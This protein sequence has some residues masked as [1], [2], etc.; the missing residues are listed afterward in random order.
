MR[1]HFQRA[2][3]L[4]GLLAALPAAQAGSLNVANTDLTLSGG[5][6]AGVFHTTNNG[7]T[8][9]TEYE[10]PDFLLELSSAADSEVGFTAAFGHLAGA[11]LWDG[12]VPAVD[13]GSMDVQYGYLTVPVGS[14]VTVDAGKLATMIGYEVAPS[15][16]NS[17]ILLGSV[18]YEQPV[19]YKGVRAT[20]SA[21]GFSAY[22]EANDDPVLGG[23]GPNADGKSVVFGASTSYGGYDWL[24]SYG[25][26]F[27]A[28]NILDLIVSGKVGGIDGAINFDYQSL[29][30]NAP[31]QDD[32]AYGIALYATFPASAMVTVPVR[33]EY[34]S[35]GTSGLYE[36]VDSAYTLTI[37]PTYHASES[38]F[39]RGELAYISADNKIFADDKGQPKD[40]NTS[41]VLEAGVTL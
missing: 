31:G 22:A 23:V 15:Y 25:N 14:A 18:W 10:V 7:S 24:A 16:A 35:D 17:N 6:T 4:V 20:Y 12:G 5:V 27:N 34:V 2:G 26:G 40:N 13:P 32:S 3:T 36:G 37:T 28:K 11:S 8:N 9:T 29:D 41:F 38:T 19:Y 39:V 33:V 21:D 1:K 30:D